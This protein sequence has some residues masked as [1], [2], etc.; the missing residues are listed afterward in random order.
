MEYAAFGMFMAVYGIILW[1]FINRSERKECLHDL[2]PIH[3]EMWHER[4]CNKCPY[5]AVCE[6]DK[7]KDRL[8]W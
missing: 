6:I 8:E 2:P 5:G 1:K 7:D 3:S 4:K